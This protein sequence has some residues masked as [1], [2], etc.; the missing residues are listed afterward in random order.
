MPL[1]ETE[2]FMLRTYTLKE[3]ERFFAEGIDDIFYAVAIA[4]G[5]LDHAMD[6]TLRGCPQVPLSIKQRRNAAFDNRI[7]A[8]SLEFIRPGLVQAYP[9][10]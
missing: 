7:A 5:K 10:D 8:L 3:A 1:H 9:T 2:A 4:P 6:L